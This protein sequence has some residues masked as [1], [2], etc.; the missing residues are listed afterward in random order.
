[1]DIITCA[2]WQRA[3]P[4]G[5]KNIIEEEIQRGSQRRKTV[6]KELALNYLTHLGKENSSELPRNDPKPVSDHEHF[7]NNGYISTERSRDGS[8]ATR[9]NNGYR[10]TDGH[11][12]TPGRSDYIHRSGS[13]STVDGG[14]SGGRTAYY[15]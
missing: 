2:E 4:S 13:V 14:V 15:D 11:A 1:V 3:G 12:S 6:Q 8:P 5:I 9:G 7:N 10:T